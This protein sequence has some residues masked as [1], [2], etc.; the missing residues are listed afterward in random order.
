M[1]LLDFFHPPLCNEVTWQE[2]HGVWPGI[3]SVSLNKKLPKGYRSGTFIKLG[4]SVKVDVATFENT[5]REATFPDGSDEF[6]RTLAAPT[7][8]I[9]E[10]VIEPPV[11]QVRIFDTRNQ[12]LVAVIEVISPANKDRPKHRDAFAYKSVSHLDQRVCVVMVDVVT[13][14]HA[15]LYA[16]LADMI[17]AKITPLNIAESSIYAVSCRLDPDDPLKFLAW[18]HK[19]T[20]G[21]KLPTLP[22][23]LSD[24]LAVPLDLEASFMEAVSGLRIPSL[25]D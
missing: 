23:W 22:L 20:V 12:K 7:L 6:M 18:D 19:L 24:D 1:P 8:M 10:D 11:Y 17:A 3:I 5:K 25:S 21:E 15:N 4:T 13:D 16:H 14:H 2:L 9:L